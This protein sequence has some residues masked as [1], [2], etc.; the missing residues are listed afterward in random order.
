MRGRRGNPRAR[1][2]PRTPLGR[3]RQ[4]RS[5]LGRRFPL[6]LQPKRP[7]A[8]GPGCPASRQGRQPRG[9]GHT[10]CPGIPAANKTCC[11]RAVWPA[12]S[13]VHSLAW[14]RAAR[15]GCGVPASIPAEPPASLDRPWA[16][17]CGIPPSRQ[18][19]AGTCSV[20][21]G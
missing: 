2:A 18:S 20:L 9:S 4:P 15:L 5:T 8:L 7:A 6:G 14:G 17:A 12:G 10:R 11:E 21:P 1:C 16:P 13:L 3:E 19:P